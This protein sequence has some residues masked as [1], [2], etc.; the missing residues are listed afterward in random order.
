[1]DAV[2]GNGQD[3]FVGE[4]HLFD[5]FRSVALVGRILLKLGSIEGHEPALETVSIRNALLCGGEEYIFAAGPEQFLRRIEAEDCDRCWQRV[6][7]WTRV[8]DQLHLSNSW[9]M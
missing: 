5:R 7:T 6:Y 2:G 3:A 9:L 1:M 8:W 4:Q